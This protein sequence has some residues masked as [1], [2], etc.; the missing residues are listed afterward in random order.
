MKEIKQNQII[1]FLPDPQIGGV[2]KNFFLISEYLSNYFNNLF[3]ITAN[4]IKKKLNNKIHIIQISKFWL[5]VNRRMFFLICTIKLFSQCLKSKNS[6][7][8]SFQGNFYAILVAIILKKKIIVRSN[9]SPHGWKSSFYKIIIFKFLLSKANIVVVNSYDFKRQIKK[10]FNVDTEVIYNPLNIHQINKDSFFKKKINFFKKKTINLVTV[11]RLVEQKNQIEI[12]KAI[13]RLGN[14]IDNYRLLIIGYGPKKEQLNKFIKTNSLQR[15]IKIIFSKKATKYINM[16]DV[17][18]LSSKYEGLPNV[19]LEA[20]CLN[21]YIISSNC[22]TGP[23]EILKQY[24]YGE[25]YNLGNIKQ[26]SYRLKKLQ[27]KYLKRKKRNI[28]KLK[29]FNF[30]KN[31]RKYLN[32]IKK[33]N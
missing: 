11:G 33:L 8:F 17:F 29:L 31:L 18:I 21:K 2:E 20:A 23:S 7:I 14:I 16:A 32:L 25:L 22:K 19:L 4:G 6:I 5:R 26:L 1:F 10:L 9:L 3:L 30:N 12:I 13:K 28:Q 27:K 15:Y 24:K